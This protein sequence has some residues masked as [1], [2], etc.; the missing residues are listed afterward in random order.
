MDTI[1]T[2]AGYIV[3]MKNASSIE[4][5]VYHENDA[6]YPSDR[7]GNPVFTDTLVRASRYAT[8]HEIKQ[9]IGGYA[10]IQSGAMAGDQCED[11]KLGGTSGHGSIDENRSFH[12]RVYNRSVADIV[13]HRLDLQLTPVDITA[14]HIDR[15]I[16]HSLA[17][18]GHTTSVATWDKVLMEIFGDPDPFTGKEIPIPE[19]W[20]DCGYLF[21]DLA[22]MEKH[23]DPKFIA[24]D[25]APAFWG[26]EELFSTESTPYVRLPFSAHR[27]HYDRDLHTRRGHDSL[28]HPDL[29]S[30]IAQLYLSPRGR[31]VLDKIVPVRVGAKAIELPPEV[32]QYLHKVEGRTDTSTEVPTA[33]AIRSLHRRSRA[34]QPQ[35]V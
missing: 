9:V 32:L 28:L 20:Q 34:N 30:V 10:F 19:G 17:S 21:M 12:P 7:E 15:A 31:D 14:D 1:V 23:G 6:F 33:V 24:E 16:Y 11:Q 29:F 27:P 8:L 4:Y 35:P 18:P 25:G 2:E 13:I 22:F 5:V 3:G 26:R